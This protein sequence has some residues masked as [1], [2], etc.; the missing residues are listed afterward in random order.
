M[1]RVCPQCKYYDAA[2]GET[3]CPTCQ[4]VLQFTLLPP[5]DQPAGPL[6]GTTAAAAPRPVRPGRTESGQV[7]EL[8][9]WILRRRRLA[10]AVVLPV[11]VA[12][13]GLFGLGRGSLREK[14][15]RI[16]VG[17]TQQE[18]N[19][20][21]DSGRRRRGPRLPEARLT[22]TGPAHLSFEENGAKIDVYFLDG[23][24][25][26]KEQRGLE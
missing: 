23:R 2:G 8:F 20:V 13:G 11:L 22:T 3:T 1:A 18:V 21:L 17:M 5:Q 24:V 16:E 14:Y 7:T 9:G 15:D 19:K 6:P 25:V 10:T 26:R 12:V 4:T